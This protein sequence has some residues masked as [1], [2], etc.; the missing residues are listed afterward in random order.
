MG[1]PKRRTKTRFRFLSWLLILLLAGPVWM[2]TFGSVNL[3]SNW[4]T[5]SHKSAGLIDTSNFPHQARVL[6]FAARAFSWRGAFAVHTWV[7]I[8]KADNDQFTVYQ[9]VGWRAWMGRSAIVIEQAA[10]DREWFG[11]KPTI[12]ADIH[13]Q[14]A[15]KAIEHIAMA[16][17]KYPYPRNYWLWPGPNSNTFTAYLLRNTP[18]L[19]VALPGNALGKDFLINTRFWGP[20]PSNSGY[21]LSLFGI[22]GLMLAREEGF[23]INILGLVFGLNWQQQALTIPGIGSLSWR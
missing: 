2:L 16:V 5:A 3:S 23:E 10:P 12:L 8:R 4:R 20:T 22:F 21:Q 17:A 14:A 13:G 19:T 7:A 6:V 1:R 11:N 15:D 9:V 18:E